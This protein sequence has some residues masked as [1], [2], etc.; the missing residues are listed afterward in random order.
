MHQA[1]K[2]TNHLSSAG[3]F[4]PTNSPVVHEKYPASCKRR[5]LWFS[6]VALAELYG[7]KAG[8]LRQEQMRLQHELQD[9]NGR[10]QNKCKD[11]KD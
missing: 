8:T 9:V 3:R 2:H 4:K 11:G 7:K 5:I 10:I 6:K 1:P